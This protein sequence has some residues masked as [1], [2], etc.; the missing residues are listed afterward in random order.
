MNTSHDETAPADASADVSAGAGKEP[1]PAA[2]VVNEKVEAAWKGRLRNVLFLA[3]VLQLIGIVVFLIGLHVGE[4]TELTF[5]LLYAPRQPVL[6]VAI[7][8]ALLAPLTR[9][10]WVL[11]VQLV[12][13]LVVLFPIMGLKIGFSRTS[14][15]DHGRI[16]IVSYNMFF[17]KM[18]RPKLAE[19]IDAMEADIWVIQGN[20]PAMT[21]HM[22]ARY[23]ERSF[24]SRSDLLVVSRFPIQRCVEP[25]PPAGEDGTAQFIGCVVETPEGPLGIYDVHPYSPRHALFGGDQAKGPNVAFREQQIGGAVEAARANGSPFIIVGDTNLPEPSPIARRWLSG[26]TD[27]FAD[28]GFGFGYTFPAK[29]PWMRID[30]AFS[31]DAVRFLD[32]RV[33]ALGQSDHRSLT[34][35]FE[36]VKPRR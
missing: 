29:H 2:K 22:K 6:V 9:R 20:Y 26:L 15:G 10:R 36:I 4:S 12:A 23:P 18:S 13:C 35:D 28:V 32:V 14:P 31:D 21:A 17:G 24:H 19:E 11:P 5:L 1:E 8:A 25:E 33:G 30:R 7:A 27:A 3:I 34:V 16:R